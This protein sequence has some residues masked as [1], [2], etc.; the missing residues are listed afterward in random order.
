MPIVPAG[1]IQYQWAK[2]MIAN[3]KK[4]R[5]HV[6][7]NSRHQHVAKCPGIS[8]V[9]RQ[10]WVQK[11]YQDIYIK[12]DGREGFEWSTPLDQTQLTVDHEWKFPY[13]TYHPTTQSEPYGI[14]KPE[15]LPTVIKL[16]S[17]WV[18]DVPKGYYLLC[19]PIPYQD[20]NRFTATTGI[21]DE[22]TNFLNVQLFWHCLNSEE[23]IPA[24]T[25]LS[26][27]FLIKKETVE[28]KIGPYTANTLKTLRKSRL[29][30]DSRFARFKKVI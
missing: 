6:P 15:T 3:M 8:L 11:S 17:P 9:A 30:S 27:Y 21:L 18:V 4:E 20:D 7:I 1:K 23:V 5:E 29:G 10:G 16:S 25:P 19:M 14:L 2:K 24:G 13:V 26:Q 12:T 22:G 28:V